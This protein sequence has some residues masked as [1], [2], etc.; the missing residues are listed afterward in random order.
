VSRV[1]LVHGIAQQYKGPESLRAEC[2]P[3]LCDGVRFAGGAVDPRDVSVAFY[4]DLFRPAGARSP[5]LPD[6]DAS[7][8][9][10]LFER[11]LLYAWWREAAER[12]PAVPAP[13]ASTRTRAPQWVQRAV[14][15]LSGSRYFG[16]LTERALVGS[17]KQVRWYLTEEDV[18]RRVRARLLDAITADTT[19]VVGHSLGSVV[20]YEGLSA[21]P[22]TPVSMLITLGSPLG[23]PKLIFDRL[24][25]PPTGGR[26]HWPRRTHQW[27]NI[28]DT[29]DIVANPKALAPLFGAGVVDVAVHNGAQAHDMRPYLTAGETGLAVL[30]GLGEPPRGDN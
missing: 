6:Y 22:G 10:H 18:R 2:A 15:A 21:E 5:G 1:V 26:G 11:E 16:G 4:G 14:Y 3:A 12:E 20:A 27:T 8:V 24:V 25:P 17:L 29:G 28:A 19:V 23:L 30:T 13:S 7:D 9:D